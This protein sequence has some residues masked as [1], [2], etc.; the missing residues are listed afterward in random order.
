MLSYKHMKNEVDYLAKLVKFRS[1]TS[2]L[3]ESGKLIDFLETFFSERGMETH[4]YVFKGFPALVAWTKTADA[5]N[6]KVMLAAHADVAEAPDELFSVRQEHGRILGRGVYDM[7]FAIAS[8]MKLVDELGDDLNSYDFGIMVTADEELGSKDGINSTKDLVAM[9]YRPKVCIL[10][11][12][13]AAGWDIEKLAKGYWRF[14]LEAF[15]KSAHGA[16]PWEGESATFKMIPALAELEEF[17]SGH[18]PHTDTLNIASIHGGEAYNQIPADVVARIE[19]RFLS[20][21]TVE[22]KRKMVQELV[23]KYDICY[24]ER[25][26]A[27]PAV[28]DLKNPMVEKYSESVQAVT[29]HIP[30]G[31]ISHAGT[32]AEYFDE[33]GIPCIVSCP[34]GGRHHSDEEW[35]DEK[36]FLEYVPILKDYL[37]RVAALDPAHS[38]VA[39][40]RA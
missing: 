6:T 26:F 24:R 13:T 31:T 32:D 17:F 20:D 4:K 18:G 27:P 33:M 19:V 11:D 38:A 25:V 14:D 1:V 3:D 16:K 28:T 15:G 9:G 39:N 21:E 40:D 22:P 23:K 2:N 7:K 35:L 34:L 30:T 37:N 10:P 5:L 8:Y 12:S 29:R 36:T